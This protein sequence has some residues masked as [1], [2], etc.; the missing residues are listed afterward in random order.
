VRD[1]EEWERAVAEVLPD[2][3]VVKPN[4]GYHGL[5]VRVIA[6][7]GRGLADGDGAP[8][9]A[10]ALW[11]ELHEDPDFHAWVVQERI[12]NH[13]VVAGLSGS[14]TLNTVRIVTLVE[15]SGEVVPLWAVL[16]LALSGGPVDN[17]RGGET[18]AALCPVGV[19]DGRLGA[20]WVPRPSGRGYG[21]VDALPD[22]TATVGVELPWW[23]RALELVSKGAL[24]FAPLRTLGWDVALAPEGPV[25][26]EANTIWGTEATPRMGAVLERLER[27]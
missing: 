27:A 16:K 2:E 24:A 19:E 9:S 10:P 22:G 20:P 12:H 8:V 7:D 26:I 17:I 5:G 25:A 11:R 14:G 15:E 21:R 1:V 4:D 18:G 23:D 6:R 3:W 13:P